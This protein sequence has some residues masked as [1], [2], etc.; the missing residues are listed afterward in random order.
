MKQ[1]LIFLLL[2]ISSFSIEP[3]LINELDLNISK[4]KVAEQTNQIILVIP[5]NYTTT[6]AMLYFY[7]KENDVWLNHLATKAHI[8]QNGL[9]KEKEGDNKTPI[10][11]Y[12]FNYYFGI[13]DNP[14]TDLPYLK[15]NESHYWIGDP[16]SPRYN[17]LVNNEIFSDFNKT[18][19]EHLIEI[20]PGYEYALNIDYNKEGTPNLGSAIFLH[21][22]TKRTYTAGCVAIDVNELKNIYPKIDKDCFI[23][24]DT[25]ENMTKYY[26]TS[27]NNSYYINN[28]LFIIFFLVFILLL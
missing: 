6:T 17:Q 25:K 9:G 11:I 8:G 21:C 27:D 23:I 12:Q 2:F 16:D 10:G 24:I 20:D 14:G 28:G 1:I 13:H 18:K 22:F 3:E 26:S 7:V 19:S 4:F 15:V 5:P